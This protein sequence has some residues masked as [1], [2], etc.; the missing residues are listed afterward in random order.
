MT[1]ITTNLEIGIVCQVRGKIEKEGSFTVQARTITDYVNLLPRENVEL[2][3][4]EQG[5]RIEGK[6][7]KTTMKGL[8]AS[9]FPLIPAVERGS[10]YTVKAG[11]LKE[12][13]AAVAFT[14]AFD[15]S[16]PEISGVY[17]NFGGNSLVLAATDSYRLA[18][19]KIKLEKAEGEAAQLIVPIRTIQELIRILGDADELVTINS[20]ENQ[21]LFGLGETKL[22]SRLIEGQ[23]PDYQQIIPKEHRTLVTLDTGEFTNTVKRASLFCKQGSNDVSLQFNPKTKEVVVSAANL[24]IGESEARQEAEVEGAENNII[25]NHRFLLDGLQNISSEECQLEINTNMSPGLLKPKGQADY[26]YIIM[27]IKQ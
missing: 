19:K 22:T 4:V 12:G 23:Y 18:E 26:L 8:E 13:L 24:Q 2:E 3:V 5:L 10:L 27:P 1:L 17:F 21:I 16:R 25:F 15:E 6:N 14:V 11:L 9:E 7:S 20:S